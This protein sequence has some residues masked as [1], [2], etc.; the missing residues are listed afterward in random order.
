VGATWGVAEV[1]KAGDDVAL[2]GQAV[3]SI[4]SVP[5]AV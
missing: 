1:G 4:A 5:Y 3:R 2:E